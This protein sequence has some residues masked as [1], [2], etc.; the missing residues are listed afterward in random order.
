MLTLHDPHS[1]I[2]W[3]LP[4][5]ERLMRLLPAPAAPASNA[6]AASQPASLNQKL[7]QLRNEGCVVAGLYRNANRTFYKHVVEL[8]MWWRD[9]DQVDGYLDQAYGLTGKKYK[10][11]VKHG[12]NFAPLFWLAWGWGSGLTD[13]KANRCSRVLNKLHELYLTQKQY[14]TD[15]V[16]KLANYIESKGGIDGLVGYGRSVDVEDDDDDDEA[17]AAPVLETR[18]MS[19]D[20]M[21]AE[22]FASARDFYCSVSAPSTADLGATIPLTADGLG[23]VLVRKVGSQYQLVGAS[24]DD[25]MVQPVAVQTYL[26]DY[27][28]LPRSVRAIIETLS[29][30][31]LPRNLQKFY[32]SLEDDA[33]KG[34]KAASA[35]SV[36]R[37]LYLHASGELLLSPMH[38]DSGVVTIAKPKQQVFANA[39]NDISL[40]KRSRR[41]VEQ[42]L[43]ADS[44]FNFYQTTSG[45]I[46][47]EF[48][49]SNLA[50]HLIRLQHRFVP[51]DYVHMDFWPL[52]TEET[53][54]SAQLVMNSTENGF[55]TWQG[56]LSLAWL[57]KFALEFTTPWLN[58]HGLNITREHQKVFLLAFGMNELTAHF[59]CRKGLF[60]N[61]VAVGFDGAATAGE[62]ATVCVLSKDFAIAMQAV[63]DLGVVSEVSVEV[64]AD[65]L[66][67]R[68]STTAADY[69]LY[70]PT[71]TIGGVRSSKH[72]KPHV[73]ATTAYSPDTFET[74]YDPADED[75]SGPEFQ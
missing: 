58:N 20:A 41:A 67:M 75:G 66:S 64:D 4:T 47:P 27:S 68:F 40:S 22:L 61:E 56:R 7:T 44:D 17:D 25:T 38:A 53:E 11:K 28:A 46:V 8:Y 50:S 21:F 45:S 13:D 69:R 72:F 48:T 42:R 30:Q 10:K 51:N 62:V 33:A 18:L 16:V 59:I 73:P 14:Q 49:I 55:G 29:T 70:I 63:A 2:C 15:S 5:S 54:P 6:E 71:C 65:M 12:I 74:Y 23:L 32:N 31:C 60:E 57:R 26:H 35:K 19:T 36:R 37:L 3:S 39:C 9:A 52:Y 43:I 1:V 24:R 34:A